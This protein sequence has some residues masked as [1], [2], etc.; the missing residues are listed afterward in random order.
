[1]TE[2]PSLNLGRALETAVAQRD[3]LWAALE[4]VLRLF[5]GNEWQ[6][7]EEQNVLRDA[8]ALAAELGG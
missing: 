5:K 7:T 4:A 3:A 2:D 1:M 8:R 6:T